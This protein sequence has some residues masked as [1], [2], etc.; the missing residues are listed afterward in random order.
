MEGAF[1]IDK[2]IRHR[3]GQKLLRCGIFLPRKYFVSAAS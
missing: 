2:Q 3:C 1:V